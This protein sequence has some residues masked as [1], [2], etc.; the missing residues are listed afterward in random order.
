[1]A[2][3]QPPQ[4]GVSP[5]EPGS[6]R[7]T[8]CLAPSGG[9]LRLERGEEILA[10]RPRGRNLADRRIE[11]ALGRLELRPDR[12]HQRAALA[13]VAHD[14]VE[15]D[16]RQ[17]RLR[18]IAVEDDEIEIL[19]LATKQISDREGD[20]RKLVDRRAVGAL[21]RR[22]QDGEVDEI[23]VGVGLQNVA[24]H[25][26]AR[27]RLAGHQQH[28]Q[29]VA[30]AVDRHHRLVVDR[31]Q[32][33]GKFGDLQFENIVAGVIDRRGYFEPF[34]DA[35]LHRGDRLAVA[36]HGD[37]GRLAMIVAVEHAGD[38]GLALADDAEAR[39]FN[40]L[41]AP[42]AL[43]LVAGD[44][45]MQR[46]LEAERR[47]VGGSVVGNAVG[48]EDRAGHALGRRVGER[49]AQ[50]RKKARC[51]CCRDPRA[52]C[53]R[54]AARRCRAPRVVWR[55]R[56]ARPPSAAAGRRCGW[57]R[58]G[59]RQPRRRLSAGADPRGASAGSA[60]PN[61]KSAATT[62]RQNAARGRAQAVSATPSA[63]ATPSAT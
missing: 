10:G 2:R 31:G 6:P 37:F 55:P 33:V 36:A 46:R 63:A 60:R 12:Q 57:S 7:V 15:I 43:A 50:A 16:L 9:D 19:D 23:D 32:F 14:V 26:F 51:P 44:Q 20:Q 58:N 27:M 62:A 21:V 45:H 41:D 48:D 18:R 24:P 17:H 11:Q 8:G 59:R 61:S 1:M 22:P 28:A 38:D 53:R 30:H 49:F 39:R 35:R 25:P 52:A 47:G 42:V 56:R 13:H 5:S 34:A 3:N 40:Q 54:N 4:A 29:L